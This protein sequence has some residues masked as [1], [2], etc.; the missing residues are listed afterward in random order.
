MVI[1]D[2]L[3]PRESLVSRE[4]TALLELKALLD[5]VVRRARE[6]PAESPVVLDPVDPLESVVVLVL[7]DSLV[8]M[9]LPVARVPLVSVVPP[10]PWEPR[11]LLER[12]VAPVSLAC[13]DPRV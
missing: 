4:R 11:E 12:A 5:P 13:P 8:L 9:E 2:H 10:D 3:D 1:W 6:E 7:V